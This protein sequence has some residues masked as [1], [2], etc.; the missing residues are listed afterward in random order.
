M[1]PFVFVVG[2]PRSGTTLL[3]RMLDAH[4]D[5]A[6]T[7][8]THFIP[9]V[10][11][12]GESSEPMS[13]ALVDR[14]LAYHR[15]RRLGVSEMTTRQLAIGAETYPEFVGRLY[16]HV[17]ASR[18]KRNAGEKTPDYVRHLSLLH[19]L[20]PHA[21]VVHII[22]DGRDVALSALDWAR[23][24]KGPGRFALWQTAPVAVCALWWA[25]FVLAGRIDG[26]ALG[27]ASYHEVRYETLVAQPEAVLRSVTTF[28]G[29][30][31]DDGMLR[32][33]DGRQ[34]TNP[35]LSAKAGW[36]PPTPGLRNWEKSMDVAD[37]AI[38]ESLVGD[39]LR[40]LGYVLTAQSGSPDR[41]AQAATW[42]AQWLAEL[43]ERESLDRAALVLAGVEGPRMTANPNGDLGL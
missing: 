33:N 10:L 20:F 16:D 17:A 14:V 36:R 24:D 23:P 7:N 41:V 4:P 26:E 40:D 15:F 28:L 13:A 29:L 3:Q 42:R 34:S 2:C 9:R 30:P 27:A 18:G 35:S 43:A 8:D 32:F 25:R 11:G 39:V 31:F 19:Q 1:N 22:R 38:F 21:K 5:L 37:V 12:K 6:V